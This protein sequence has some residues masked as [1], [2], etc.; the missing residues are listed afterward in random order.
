MHK[1]RALRALH[2][3]GRYDEAVFRLSATN[4][5]FRPPPDPGADSDLQPNAR[6]AR[7]LRRHIAGGVVAVTTVHGEL[8][9]ATTVTAC[10]VAS[11]EPFQILVSI[12]RDS[13]MEDW[14]LASGVFAISVLPWHQQ[15][16]ADQFAGFT[17]RASGRFDRIAHFVVETGA[18]IVDDCIGWADCRIVSNFET[19]DHRCFLGDVTAVGPGHGVPEEPLVYYLNRYR[20]LG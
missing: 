10:F 20:R 12:E 11:N 9:R 2:T 7:W 8:Y 1:A 13:Q 18:P 16:L 14:M 4:D 17:P 3:I 15:F 5:P 6:G 19:G